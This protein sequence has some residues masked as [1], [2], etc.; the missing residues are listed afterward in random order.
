MVLLLV[1]SI[2]GGTYTNKCI[3]PPRVFL[4]DST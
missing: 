4:E 3:S 1:L 2:G